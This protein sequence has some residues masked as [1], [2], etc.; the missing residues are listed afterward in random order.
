MTQTPQKLSFAV[1][2]LFLTDKLE[3]L[4]VWKELVRNLLLVCIE[5]TKFFEK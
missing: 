2:F 4:K 1:P 5:K 3:S